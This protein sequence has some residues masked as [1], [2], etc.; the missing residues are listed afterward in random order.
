MKTYILNNLEIIDVV[1]IGLPAAS[2]AGQVFVIVP[3]FHGSSVKYEC[4]YFK[5][6]YSA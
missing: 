4:S 1:N 6:S 2:W 5:K 3:G